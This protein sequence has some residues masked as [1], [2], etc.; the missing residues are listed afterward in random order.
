MLFSDF[1]S[2][3]KDYGWFA[4]IF[5]I[6]AFVL[7]KF[8][9]SHYKKWNTKP[10]PV[11][12]AIEENEEE[13]LKSHPF[14][15]DQFK[16]LKLDIPTSHLVENKPVRERVF[17]DLLTISFRTV[18]DIVD[19]LVHNDDLSE[20]TAE[21]WMD[22]VNQLITKITNNT[23]EHAKQEG[24]PDIVITKFLKWQVESINSLHEYVLI[25]GNSKLYDTNISKTNTLLFI[26]NLLLVSILGDA[27]RVLKELNGE[28]TGLNYKGN[29]IE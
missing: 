17:K 19:G 29:V 12:P 15:N 3:I 7:L 22:N 8:V 6:I 14:F 9:L 25:L 28:I 26:M 2:I 23:E 4:G 16:I 5:T 18:Y 21:Q 20:W 1:I 27:E 13:I 24:I 10:V 11:E